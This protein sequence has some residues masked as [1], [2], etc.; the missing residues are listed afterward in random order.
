MTAVY[1]IYDDAADDD[2]MTICKCI[3]E[4]MVTMGYGRRD[5]EESLAENK[6]DS[7]TATYLLLGRPT[8]DVSKP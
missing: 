6:Y 3:T 5:I 1:V 8:L 2:L 4:V 7:L